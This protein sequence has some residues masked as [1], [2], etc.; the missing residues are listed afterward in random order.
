VRL[1]LLV[2]SFP[3]ISEK[4]I[5]DQVAGLID[6]GIE[7]AIYAAMRPAEAKAHTLV[8]RYGLGAR[9]VYADVPRSAR[10]RAVEAP[11]LLAA[12]L[13]RHP[14]AALRAF[15][16]RAYATA[17]RN[18][19]TLYFLRAVEGRD[20]P[21]IL[22]CHFGP[23]GLVGAYLK[24]CGFARRLVVTFHGSDINGYPRRYG[25]GMYRALYDRADA[26]TCGSRFIRDRLVANGC[27]EGKI[28][29]LPV[30]VRISDYPEA[31]A[32]REEGLILSV[33][34]LAEA[35][36]FRYA[37]DALAAL[38]L[39]V[40]SARYAIAGG[41]GERAAL[42]RLTRERGVEDAVSFL[43]EQSDAEVAALYRRASIFVLPSVRAANGAEEGQGLV[44]QEAQ[45]A[46][47][48]VVSTRIGG[49]AEGMIEGETGL[50]VPEK[51]SAALAAAMAR[52]LEDAPLRARMGRAGRAFAAANY[53]VP[54]LARRLIGLYGSLSAPKEGGQR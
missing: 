54:M 11:A 48:P 18:L 9:T 40:P 35:K 4:F 34:R 49:I 47:L 24:D 16:A 52:L 14:A 50:L 13:A 32:P 12:C 42:E 2:G 37:I 20:R 36:G 21:D 41:G 10:R 33:G 53:D 27:P 29:V 28:L 30:G 51:D 17:A 19:K 6:A 3:S 44:L 39:R 22:H 8:E 31:E 38:R 46:G 1:A 45:A 5:L 15:D 25:E 26:V 7:P 43:G 23:Y